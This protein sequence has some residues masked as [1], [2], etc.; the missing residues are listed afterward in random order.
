MVF[1]MRKEGNGIKKG[2]VIEIDALP[3]LSQIV[4]NSTRHTVSYSYNKSHTIV[5]EYMPDKTKDMFQV[6]F[7]LI[8]RCNC[9]L[10]VP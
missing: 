1:K 2:A 9:T 4:K 5:V 8:F 10:S 7:Q 3:K 6:K